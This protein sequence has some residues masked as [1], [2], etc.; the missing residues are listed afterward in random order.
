MLQNLVKSL[1][2]VSD[3]YII[4]SLI[5]ILFTPPNFFYIIA[6]KSNGNSKSTYVSSMKSSQLNSHTNT[7]RYS[8]HPLIQW[9][10]LCE[11]QVRVTLAFSRDCP[12][13]QQADA[14]TFLV[15]FPESARQSMSSLRLL[16][17]LDL[18]CLC[19]PFI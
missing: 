9:L 15:S 10:T 4:T 5:H 11:A 13:L 16:T 2:I 6:G 12:S 18:N 19:R 14:G 3:A 8:P 1:F 17:D 7:N